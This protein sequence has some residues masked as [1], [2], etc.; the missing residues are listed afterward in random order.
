MV[1]F[2]LPLFSGSP[3]NSRHRKS[4]VVADPFGDEQEDEYRD[5]FLR[6][7]FGLHGERIDPEEIIR[8]CLSHEEL[9]KELD[10]KHDEEVERAAQL[11]QSI[12]R[13]TVHR[14]EEKYRCFTPA[15]ND[16][17][18]SFLQVKMRNAAVQNI[19]LSKRGT[20]QR[21]ESKEIEIS[22][23]ERSLA[24]IVDQYMFV[25][26]SVRPIKVGSLTRTRCFYYCE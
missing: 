1:L 15:N 4:T 6:I 14:H 22:A 19:P 8:I 24:T 17:F 7:G 5:A 13:G 20:S 18:L 11:R 9:K 10:A 21:L 12:V 2:S 26:Q 16:S 3:T 23:V 25:D